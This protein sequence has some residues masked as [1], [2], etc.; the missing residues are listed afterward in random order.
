LITEDAVD[1]YALR[2]M[3]ESEALRMSVPLQDADDLA[4]AAGYIEQL[5]VETD[6]GQIGRLN[7]MLHLSLYAKNHNKRLMRLV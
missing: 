6:F 5:D 4:A 3:L 2:I 7:R 1:A